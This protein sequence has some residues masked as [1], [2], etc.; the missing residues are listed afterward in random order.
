MWAGKQDIAFNG[1]VA[2]SHEAKAG[3]VADAAMVPPASPMAKADGV[4]RQHLP[5]LPRAATLLRLHLVV[6]VSMVIQARLPHL[7][8]HLMQML[9]Q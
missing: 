8:H 3:V 5:S 2:G 9:L 1:I 6:M 7:Q 4:G